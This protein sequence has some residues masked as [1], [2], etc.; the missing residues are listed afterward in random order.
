MILYRKK[1]YLAREVNGFLFA[2][3]TL[4]EA[5]LDEEMRYL[6]NEA[7]MIDEG[8]AGYLSV[9]DLTT[10]SDDKIWF[11]VYGEHL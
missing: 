10:M 7:I 3:I 2:D 6:S 4:Q 9:D 8:V 1:F 5:L 11:T